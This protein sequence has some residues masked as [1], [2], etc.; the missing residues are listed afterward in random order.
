MEYF[1][2]VSFSCFLMLLANTA[3]SS[4]FY[5]PLDVT[6][7]NEYGATTTWQLTNDMSCK[8]IVAMPGVGCPQSGSDAVIQFSA[9]VEHM[10]G[11]TYTKQVSSD[12][13]ETW[14]LDNL[15]ANYTGDF[16]K[17]SCYKAQKFVLKMVIYQNK[18]YCSRILD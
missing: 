7:T 11:D 12:G 14:V 1:L 18:I 10:I 13:Q 6:V 2:K 4:E 15:N 17:F 8:H 3:M 9:P 5:P 16:K